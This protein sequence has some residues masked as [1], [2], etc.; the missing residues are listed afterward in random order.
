MPLL[1]SEQEAQYGNM[2]QGEELW[3]KGNTDIFFNFTLY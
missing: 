1:Y 3:G 2:K